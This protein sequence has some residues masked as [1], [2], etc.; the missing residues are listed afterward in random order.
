VTFIL[1]RLHAATEAP[2]RPVTYLPPRLDAS[3][4]VDI[5]HRLNVPTQIAA[6][7]GL[8]LDVKE[9]DKALSATT[10]SVSDKIR[11]KL[12]LESNRLLSRGGK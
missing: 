6:A 4:C 12:A 3:A 5:L 7:T 10:L 8:P 9:I 2:K 1:D 11:F